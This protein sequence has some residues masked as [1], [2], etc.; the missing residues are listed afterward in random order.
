MPVWWL[1]QGLSK[2]SFSIQRTFFKW[3]GLVVSQ[4]CIFHFQIET[5]VYGIILG[6]NQ[7]HIAFNVILEVRENCTIAVLIGQ[8]E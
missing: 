5:L 7:Y 6:L 1:T 4:S 2:G 8:A 3:C